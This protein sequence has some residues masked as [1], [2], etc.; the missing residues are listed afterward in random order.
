MYSLKNRQNEQPVYLM[1]SELR[2]IKK[3]KKIV[4]IRTLTYQLMISS[5]H[6]QEIVCENEFYRCVFSPFVEFI[7]TAIVLELRHIMSCGS[8]CTRIF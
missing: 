5:K 4:N 6:V 2:A 1:T 7:W 3:H 8:H